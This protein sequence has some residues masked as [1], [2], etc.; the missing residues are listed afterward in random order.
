MTSTTIIV[1]LFLTFELPQPRV[2]G[3]RGPGEREE[4]VGQSE[5][6]GPSAHYCL[7]ASTEPPTDIFFFSKTDRNQSFFLFIGIWRATTSAGNVSFRRSFQVLWSIYAVILWYLPF[8][9]IFLEGSVNSP[10]LLD[11]GRRRRALWRCLRA[12]RGHWQ[13]S[14]TVWSLW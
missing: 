9:R 6:I 3:L 4:K 14:V 5:S 11:H 13:V 1:E 10:V 12:V 7:P 2:A 8:G